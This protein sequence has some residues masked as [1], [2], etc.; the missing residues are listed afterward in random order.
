MQKPT[1]INILPPSRSAK[2]RHSLVLQK[3][4]EKLARLTPAQ[5]Q[6]LDAPAELK[7]AL[8]QYAALRSHEAKR[9]HLQYIGRL[10]RELPCEANGLPADYPLTTRQPIG[11]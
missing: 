8:I 3:A 5:I 4:G 6:Q 7:E 9:R 2:K 11:Y 10:M 1:D